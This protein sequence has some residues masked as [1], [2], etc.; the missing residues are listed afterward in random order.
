[1]IPARHLRSVVLALLLAAV[2][3][4]QLAAAQVAVPGQ[5]SPPGQPPRDNVTARTG[6]ATIRGHVFDGTSGQPLRKAQ[7]RAQSPELREN[8]VALTDANGAYELTN[9][10]AGR[11]LLLSETARR[12]GAV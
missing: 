7:V 5:P 12:G 8:R 3:C 4:A 10:A 2:F 1:M 6:T 11:Y 9:L